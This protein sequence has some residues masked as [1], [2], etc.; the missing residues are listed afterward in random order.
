MTSALVAGLLPYDSGKT[1]FARSL[2]RELV[3]RG[4]DVG[5]SKP[6]SGISGWYQYDCVL[7]SIEH[8]FLVGEDMYKLHS[9]AK[10]SD[11]IALE[12]P[13]IFLLLPPDPERVG[14]ET[15]IYTSIGFH[16]QVSVIRVTNPKE[17]KHYYVPLNLR[18][19]T[20]S[21]KKEVEKF[22]SVVDAEPIELREVEE[23]LVSSRKDA[24]E[25][26]NYINL[27]HEF[28]VLESFNNAAAPT[29]GSLDVDV[30]VVVAPGKAAV[31]DGRDYRKAVSALSSVKEPWKITTEEV[32]QLLHP[33]TKME[34]KP[35]KVEGV[36][37]Q[38]RL[39]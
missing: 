17:S 5:I 11:P 6:I 39:I 16:H 37:K 18:R 8:G 22:L 14:W 7:K 2:V 26:L 32:V 27:K 31:Y 3:D 28:T 23:I 4:V 34:L 33:T 21:L 35:K 38:I 10:S 19:T 13:V 20:D 30:V 12:G 15:S 25:C 24:D 36:L 9:V 1:T 29:A